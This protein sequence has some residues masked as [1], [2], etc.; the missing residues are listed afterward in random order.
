MGEGRER[1]SG[2]ASRQTAGYRA[3]TVMLPSGCVRRDNCRLSASLITTL[4]IVSILLISGCGRFVRRWAPTDD[5][6]WRKVPKGV[7]FQLAPD[8]G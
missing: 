4:R 3:R 7:T 8:K 6:G 1:V 5:I 2:D